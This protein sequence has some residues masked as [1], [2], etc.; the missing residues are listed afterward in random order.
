MADEDK[1]KTYIFGIKNKKLVFPIILLLILLIA[2]IVGLFYY[3]ITN[4]GF[5]SL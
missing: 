5:S 4:F 3:N 2:S 1:N